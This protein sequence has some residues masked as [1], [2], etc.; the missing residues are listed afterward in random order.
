MTADLNRSLTKWQIKELSRRGWQSGVSI[1]NNVV[2]TPRAF[3]RRFC[4]NRFLQKL[5]EDRGNVSYSD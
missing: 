2:T 1:V 5:L 3:L 4:G